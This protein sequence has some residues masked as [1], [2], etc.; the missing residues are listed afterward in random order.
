[1]PLNIDFVQILLHMLN[2]VI[3]AGGLTLLLYRPVS[4][5]LSARA[6]Q[7]ENARR[8]NEDAAAK[9][10]EM[11]A[12][13]EAKLAAAEGEIREMRAEAEK[14]TAA[15][16][17]AT[18]TEAKKKASAILAAAEHEAEERREHI[19]DSAQTEIG[20]LV[21]AASQKLLGDTVTPER[22]R[23]LYDEFIRRAETAI[24]EKR[25]PK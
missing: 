6:E 22:D 14:T 24:R 7:L 21:L 1:M 12:E 11:K 17:E 20:E 10:A 19:L 25:S 8:E 18:L 4:R 9:N 5:Y 16:A 3:L 13:Y 15:A 2:F 23:G